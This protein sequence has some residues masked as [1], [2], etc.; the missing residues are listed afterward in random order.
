M[1]SMIFLLVLS[2]GISSTS[3]VALADGWDDAEIL[4]LQVSGELSAPPLLYERI[5]NE[6]AVIRQFYPGMELIHVFPPWVPGELIVGL[7]DEAWEEFINGEYHGLDSLNALYGPVQ[8]EP[9]SFIK[10]LVLKFPFHYN[11]ECL[12]P[13][14]SVAEG[15]RWA[16]PNHYYGDGDNIYA[17]IDDSCLSIYTFRRGWEDCMSGCISNHFWTFYVT[18]DTVTYMRHEGDQI[19]EV[20]FSADTTT[21]IAPLTVQFVDLSLIGMFGETSWSWDFDNDGVEDS[22]EQHPVYT[23]TMPGS[24][25][26]KLTVTNG[27]VSHTKTKEGYITVGSEG[28]PGS[29]GGQTFQEYS[30][31][32]NYPNPFNPITEIKYTLPVDCQVKVEIYNTLGE[33]VT[34]LVDGKQKAGYRAVRWDATSSPSGIYFYRLQVRR[35][36]DSFGAGDFVQTRKMIL[37]K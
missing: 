34:T 29:S 19:L 7:T 31:N 30:L 15:V 33:K 11:P 5:S 2:I 16:Q 12:S 25:T 26:I 27:E 18:D 4:A 9:L 6:L 10:V 13:M 1:R 22:K 36:P 21:G 8:I 35:T 32:Q 14:Y 37:L 28:S 23:Y 20:D 17:T 3:I 24:Y